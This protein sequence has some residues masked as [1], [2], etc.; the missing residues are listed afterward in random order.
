MNVCAIHPTGRL[1]R[2]IC[3]KPIVAKQKKETRRIGESLFAKPDEPTANQ[4][5]DRLQVKAI[6]N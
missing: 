6:A 1:R 3:F 4:S 5:N 2:S